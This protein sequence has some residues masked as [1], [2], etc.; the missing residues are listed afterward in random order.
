MMTALWA[1]IL[2]VIAAQTSELKVLDVM[3]GDDSNVHRPAVVMATNEQA[4][5]RIWSE[6]HASVTM[7]GGATPNNFHVEGDAPPHVD[8]RKA[9]V[10]A[11]FA[12]NTP[13]ITGFEAKKAE[14]KGGSD[15]LRI[16]PIPAPQSANNRYIGAAFA[17]VMLNNTRRPLTVQMDMRRSVQAPPDWQVIAKFSAEKKQ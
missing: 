13:G 14:P 12:G 15:I 8:F 10:L 16:R 9:R 5:Q 11:I 6:H 4:W 7:S 2:G 1:L 17:F 3:T